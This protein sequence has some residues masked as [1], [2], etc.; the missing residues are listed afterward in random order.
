MTVT[1]A[2]PLLQT[3]PGRTCLVAALLATASLV[4]AQEPPPPPVAATEQTSPQ[5]KQD[6]K[7]LVDQAR[8]AY[9]AGEF[10]QAIALFKRAYA[11]DSLPKHLYNMARAQEKLAAYEE[12]IALLERYI[13]AFRFQNNNYDPPNKADVD[14]LIRT[15]RQRAYQ[16]LPTVIIQ[17]QPPGATVELVEKKSTLGSTPL[18]THMAPGTHKLRLRLPDHADLDAAVQVPESGQ[19]NVVFSLK[20]RARHAAISIWCNV[21]QARIAIDGRVV[22]MTPL[23][24]RL[25]VQ[26][27]QHQITLSREGYGMVQ[28]M[29][30]VPEDRE[31]QVS[32]LMQPTE[33]SLSWR[34]GVGWPLIIAGLGGVGAGVASMVEANTYYAGS[35]DFQHWERYQN[36]GYGVGGG[37]LGL[38]FAFVLW[39]SVREN[40]ADEDRVKGQQLAPGRK[41]VPL[42]PVGGKP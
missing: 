31:L 4:S 24:G 6:A 15:M 1:R 30:E 10:K 27:G 35:P 23:Q 19:V 38:G 37:V 9:S 17:S 21:R 36:L 13:Q 12:A 39:D 2:R 28:D 34:S 16:A 18:T 26:P 32:Y 41:L 3:A 11:I 29:V 42:G 8:A 20:A 5:E 33:T 40:I 25:D 14:S 7:A 22:A